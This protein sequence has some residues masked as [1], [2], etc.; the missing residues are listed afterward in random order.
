MV[1]KSYYKRDWVKNCAQRT[2]YFVAT[3][4]QKYDRTDEVPLIFDTY[5]VSMSLKEATREKTQ[6]GLLQD[7]RLY[8]NFKSSY[9]EASV[10]HLHEDG[11]NN[12]PRKQGYDAF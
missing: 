5:D 11:A 2:E 8:R 10:A 4:E 7:H 6:G 3:I 12:L 9:E 1:L